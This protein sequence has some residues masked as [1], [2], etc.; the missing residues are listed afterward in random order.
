[1]LFYYIVVIYCSVYDCFEYASFHFHH[2]PGSH[3]FGVNPDLALTRS[4]REAPEYSMAPDGEEDHHPQVNQDDIP[5]PM[6][7]Q[8]RYKVVIGR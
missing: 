3:I 6:S 2:N 4:K 1:M 5:D 7:E 8:R